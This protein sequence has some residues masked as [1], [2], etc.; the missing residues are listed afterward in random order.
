MIAP[1]RTGFIISAPE[2]DADYAA[3]KLDQFIAAVGALPL[4]GGGGFHKAILGAANHGARA[5]LSREEIFDH[6]QAVASRGSRPVPDAEIYDAIDK[7][8][9]EA[10]NNWTR[11]TGSVPK[12][13]VGTAPRKPAG[14]FADE[15]AVLA[16]LIRRGRAD[17]P[18]LSELSPVPIPAEPREQTALLLSTLYT[19]G[20]TLFI[21]DSGEGTLARPGR[22]IRGVEDWLRILN[23]NGTLPPMVIPNPLTGDQGKTKNGKDSYRADS[24]VAAF[25]FA[26][27]E[28]DE[29]PTEDQLAFWAAAPWP[30][31]ALTSS[32]GKSIHAWLNAQRI[33]EM[34]AGRRILT[35]HDWTELIERDLFDRLLT[36]LGCDGAC[37]NESRISRLAGAARPD[38]GGAIQRLIYLDPEGGTIPARAASEKGVRS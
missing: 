14:F 17:G 38:K 22:E 34:E 11:T 15:K 29:L 21:A 37:K 36:P 35:A 12:P 18:R 10:G 2:T 30:L 24:C 31:F 32:G 7:A 1:R 27:A 20:D 26:V 8:I 33:A 19:P 16:E 9:G 3:R 5:G 13:S 25:R 23:R 6:L 28:M 4:P